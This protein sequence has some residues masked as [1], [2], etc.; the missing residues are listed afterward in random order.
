[1]RAAAQFPR[2][3]AHLNDA[4]LLAVLLP[5][6]RERAQCPRLFNRGVEGTNVEVVDQHLI[7]L[8]FGVCNHGRRH[9][10]DRSEV[11]PEAAWRVLRAGLGS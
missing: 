5:E 6:Q 2:V 1:M 8:V 4:D 11:E 7:D 10:P 3:V 9:G